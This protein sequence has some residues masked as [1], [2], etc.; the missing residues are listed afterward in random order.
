ME[1]AAKAVTELETKPKVAPLLKS[2][3][4]LPSLGLLMV[5]LL[6]G[7][8]DV[9]QV[10]SKDYWGPGPKQPRIYGNCLVDT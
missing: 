9:V 7:Q 3:S 10:T 1:A 2:S 6:V 8:E 5:R 4:L